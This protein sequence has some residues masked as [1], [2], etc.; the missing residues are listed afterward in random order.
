MT[1]DLHDNNSNGFHRDHD[2]TAAEFMYVVDFK[3]FQRH[4][5]L[6]FGFMLAISIVFWLL[7]IFG[8]VWFFV[9]KK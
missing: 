3:N 9:F 8:M 6:R 2:M 1:A 4:E 7:V 5:T